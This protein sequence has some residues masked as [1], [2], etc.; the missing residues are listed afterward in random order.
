MVVGGGRLWWNGAGVRRKWGRRL[1]GKMVN[2]YSTCLNVGGTKEEKLTTA[3]LLLARAITQK[4]FIRTNNRLRTSSNTRNQAVIQDGRVDIQTKNAGYGRNGNRNAMRHNRNQAFNAGTRSDESN[5]IVQRVLRTKSNPRKANVQCY[6]C[7]E[8]GH[9]ARD[10]QKPRVRDTK[11]F[12]EQMFLVMK[13]KAG[14]NL[15]DEENDF[16]LD[17]SYGDETLEELTAT[18]IMI[19]RIQLVDDNVASK[20]SYDAKVVSEVNA[21]TKVHEQVNRVQRKTIIHTY[22]DDQI[23]SNIIF[24]DPYIENN[25]GTSEHDSTA[26]DEYHDIKMFAYNVQREV[27]NKKRL[28]NELK[29]Q[30]ISMGEA[31]AT[32]CFTQNRSI[33]HTQYKKTLYELIRGRKPNVQYFYVF[34]SL[35]YPTND[36]DDLGKMKP[37]ADIGIFVGYSESSRG[38]C[39]YNRRTKKIMETIHA[40][41]YELTTMASECNHLEPEFNCT[42]FQDLS[43]DS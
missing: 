4:F 14:R 23:D 18:V 8:K 39:I 24:D 34:G 6:N 13:D 43:E 37:K 11:Y 29:K 15:K 21:S 42:N 40:K 2:R 1:A 7:N 31:I 5:Q 38:F 28:N 16:M 26:H 25:G 17:N 33:V 9:Y 12:R 22:D 10:C 35:C 32:A 3:I 27:E 36:R 20:S 30:K 19:A 41:F